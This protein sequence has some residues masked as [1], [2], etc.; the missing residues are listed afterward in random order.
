MDRKEP[1]YLSQRKTKCGI[2][3]ASPRRGVVCL[4]LDRFLRQLAHEQTSVGFFE[5]LHTQAT[6]NA[7]RSW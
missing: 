2:A 6:G 1:D 3:V 5:L 4:D 7:P